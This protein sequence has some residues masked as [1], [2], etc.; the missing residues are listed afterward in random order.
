MVRAVP[1]TFTSNTALMA[2]SE[3]ISRGAIK[4]TPALHTV[5]YSASERL[6]RTPSTAWI[7]GRGN[8][9]PI[10]SSGPQNTH[11]HGCRATQAHPHIGTHSWLCPGEDAERRGMAVPNTSGC[12]P[13]MQR[14]AAA[15]ER[16]SVTS[17][18]SSSSVSGQRPPRRSSSCSPLARSRIVANTVERVWPCCTLQRWDPPGR[19]PFTFEPAGSV[20]RQPHRQPQPDAR[21]AAGDQHRGLLHRHH[22]SLHG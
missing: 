15:S 7:R 22:R 3:H 1:N 6:L 18:C 2:C 8:P 10:F 16:G 9:A 5:G 11:P 17:S 12:R 20:S 14:T 19:H 21:G 4:P 13:R